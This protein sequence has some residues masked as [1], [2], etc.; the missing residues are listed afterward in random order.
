MGEK[1]RRHFPDPAT[2]NVVKQV[3]LVFRPEKTRRHP[4]RL[5]H[6]HHL[7]PGRFEKLSAFGHPALSRRREKCHPPHHGPA[8]SLSADDNAEHRCR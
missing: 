4:H 1:L 7:F 3:K 5:R 8:H 6:L 2:K